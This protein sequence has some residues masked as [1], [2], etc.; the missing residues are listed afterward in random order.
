M[1]KIRPLIVPKPKRLLELFA[2]T[3]SIGKVAETLG[4]EVVS[5]DIDT[6]RRCTITADIMDWDYKVYPPHY[7]HTV[8]ASPP[9]TYY[10]TLANAAQGVCRKA[11]RPYDLEERR[12]ESDLI[13]A[14]VLEIIKYY[15]PLY[16][17]IENPYTGTLKS[18][19]VVAGIP[20]FVADYCRYGYNYKKST[21]FWTNKTLCLDRCN[22]ICGRMK[23]TRHLD[24]IGNFGSQRQTQDQRYSIPPDLCYQ[25]LTQ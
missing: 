6:S 14:R 25:L 2:G 18:R 9:C 10:S 7:F 3:K 19:S 12:K 11:G 5:L 24:Q 20:Y 23:G 8:W 22:G 13:V 16:Y 17:I 15:D 4:Y 1:E 21:A